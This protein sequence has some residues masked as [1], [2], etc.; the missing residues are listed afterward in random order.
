MCHQLQAQ[1]WEELRRRLQPRDGSPR[2]VGT[3]LALIQQYCSGG[4]AG[5]AMG[6][7]GKKVL[8]VAEGGAASRQSPDIK[9]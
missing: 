8:L 5:R 2:E 4:E 3:A 7:N 9:S 1:A 6:V